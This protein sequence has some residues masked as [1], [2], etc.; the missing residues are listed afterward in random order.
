MCRWND[1][2]V[3]SLWIVS[4]LLKQNCFSA[5]HRCAI[6]CSKLMQDSYLHRYSTVKKL[7]KDLSWQRTEMIWWNKLFCAPSGRLPRMGW[8]AVG[9]MCSVCRKIGWKSWQSE[10]RRMP[11]SSSPPSSPCRVFFFVLVFLPATKA[12]IDLD[13]R[14]FISSRVFLVF[15]G[16][17]LESVLKKFLFLHFPQYS[18]HFGDTLTENC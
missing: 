15:Q 17:Q 3:H 8:C 18:W 13:A 16:R 2:S 12:E 7:S 6:I 10:I 14:Q 4:P 1:I 5:A 9:I 11:G